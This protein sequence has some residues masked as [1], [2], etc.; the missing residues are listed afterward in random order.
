MSTKH[1]RFAA[2]AAGLI[3]AGVGSALAEARGEPPAGCAVPVTV[4]P[5][6]LPRAHLAVENRRAAALRV[7]V[8]A[9]TGSGLPRT[10][11]GRLDPFE[12]RV[13]PHALPAGRNVLAARAAEGEDAI[14]RH[15]LSVNNRGSET[16]ARRYLWRVEGR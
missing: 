12:R 6:Y 2:L 13:F 5:G 14:L 7:W 1:G 4:A 3:A 16:C 11:L 8:E 9:R 10:E 15:V